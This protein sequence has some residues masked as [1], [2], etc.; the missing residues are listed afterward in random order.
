MTRLAL[1]VGIDYYEVGNPL[2]G[3]V[4]DAGKV[5]AVLERHDDDSPNF[6]CKLMLA[7]DKVRAISRRTLKDAVESFFAA[8]PEIALFYFAGHGYVSTTGGYLL[9]SDARDGDDGLPLVDVLGFANKSR[10]KNKI[11]VL[12]SCHSG[13]A[14]T[15]PNS[16]QLATLAEG[17]TILTAST[18]E[19]YA[20]EQDAQGIFTS[21]L[22]DALAGGAANLT[23]DVTPGSVYAHIDQSLGGFEQRPVFKTNVKQFVS[24]RRVKPPVVRAD[25]RQIVN[26]FPEPDLDFPLDPTFEPEKKGRDKGMPEPI[27][28]NVEK[29][30]VLQAYNRVNLVVPVGVKH[31]WNAAMESKA[32]RLTTLGHHYHRLVTKGRI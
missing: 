30:R 28:A 5:R 10:A 19:Q 12:D 15:P 4:S 6:D 16:G 32:C 24:L 14:G 22:V 18:A 25:L 1:I 9:G 21:L 13:I 27:P 2:H 3:C 11:I 17:L 23:G 31:M 8:D 29:F 26:L 20:T 7:P